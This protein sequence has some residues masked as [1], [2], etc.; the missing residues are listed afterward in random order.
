MERKFSK[1]QVEMRG[2]I[3]EVLYITRERESNEMS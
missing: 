1:K 3:V 2:M